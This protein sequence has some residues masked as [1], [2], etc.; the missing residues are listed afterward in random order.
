[1]CWVETLQVFSL[2]TYPKNKDYKFSLFIIGPKNSIKIYKTSY[3]P[4]AYLKVEIRTVTVQLV[5]KTL[6]S[7]KCRGY[8]SI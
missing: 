6:T 5:I 4:S 3:K 8:F 7:V 1:M 2:S